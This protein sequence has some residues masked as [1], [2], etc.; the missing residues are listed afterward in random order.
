M[1]IVTGLTNTLREKNS[2]EILIGLHRKSNLV[3]SFFGSITEQLVKTTNRMVILSRCYMPVDTMR[4]IY[5]YVPVNAEYETGFKT[6]LTRVSHLSMQIGRRVNFLASKAT[7][8]YI[9]N[10][11]K[12]RSFEYSR[13]YMEMENWDDFIVLS[14]NITTEDLFIVIYARK[15]S[16]SRN[17][18]SEAM[19]PY[20][21]KHFNH[22]NIVLIYPA[23]FGAS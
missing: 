12:E 22:S 21:S 18:D 14:S 2:S 6:W 10:Y 4:N 19:P 7:M 3:D 17:G 20:I 23:Q 11:I 15:G 8:P 1:N 13:R 5:V 16:L 9:E